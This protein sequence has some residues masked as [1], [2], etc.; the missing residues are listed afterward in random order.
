MWIF[1]SQKTRFF[2]WRSF[3][4]IGGGTMGAQFYR[5]DIVIDIVLDPGSV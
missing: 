3:R 1:G 2:Y 5:K 4:R